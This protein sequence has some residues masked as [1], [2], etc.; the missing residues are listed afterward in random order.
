MISIERDAYI[1]FLGQLE[2]GLLEQYC[3]KKYARV[4]RDCRIVKT[5]MRTFCTRFGEITL[6]ITHV[7]N[8]VGEYFSP[9]LRFLG[10][11]KYQRIPEDLENRIRDKACKMSYRDTAEDVLNSFEFGISRQKVWRINQS[12]NPIAVASPKNHEVL[13]ADGTKIRSNNG[14]HLEPRAIMS[15]DAEKKEKCLLALEITKSWQEMAEKLDFEGFKVLVADG[16]PGLREA[17]V[18]PHMRFQFCHIHAVR[19]LSFYLWRDKLEKTARNEFMKPLKEI[20]YTVQN[21]TKKY[22]VNKDKAR[23]LQRIHWANKRISELTVQLEKRECEQSADFLDRNKKYLFTAATL[24]ITNNLQ[25]PWNTNTA[26]RLM[27]EIGKRTKK[28]SMRWSANG[29][30]S[31]LSAVLKRYFLPQEKRTYKNIYGDDT[32]GGSSQNVNHI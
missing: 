16:E 18:K 4:G 15:I 20:L 12:N 28:K 17:L 6:K 3:G 5:V 27:K 11:G 25:I 23:L 30:I 7:K 26:E 19:D 10:I 22:F 13:L 32:V 29:L 2:G 24:A 31:I 9:L 14:G 1:C 8:A 21:S